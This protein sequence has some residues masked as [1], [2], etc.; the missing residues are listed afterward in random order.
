MNT[1]NTNA[2]IDNRWL[3]D[4]LINDKLIDDKP[5]KL[6]DDKKIDDKSDDK[7]IDYLAKYRENDNEIESNS[8]NPTNLQKNFLNLLIA[9]IQ[10]QDPTNPLQNNEFTSQLA[11][12]NTVIGI[13][14]LHNTIENF[15]N[16][17]QQHENIQLS[18]LIGRYI[19]V[20]R[21]EIVHTEKINTNFGVELFGQADSIE[22]KILDKNKK[23]LYHNLI[24]ENKKPGI[25]R[26]SWNGIDLDGNVVK[27]GKYDITVTAKNK[28]KNVPANSL[29]ESKVHSINLSSSNNTLID[30][31]PVGEVDLSSIRKILDK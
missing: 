19:M 23:V 3:K 2:P 29:S 27:N 18:S 15:S 14:Q 5:I 24:K 1:I 17:V 26:F 16:Q 4:K 30:L 10:N 22:I 21:N 13:Q 11:L 7:P 25:Y 8:S 20:P 28:E 6:T 31:G 12:I 9:Q